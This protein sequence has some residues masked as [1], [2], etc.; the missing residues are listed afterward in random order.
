[1]KK[2]V[3]M[4]LVVLAIFVFLACEPKAPA[5]VVSEESGTAVVVE[6]PATNVPVAEPQKVEPAK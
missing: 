5:P 4:I 1:M 3:V 6:Q 2:K